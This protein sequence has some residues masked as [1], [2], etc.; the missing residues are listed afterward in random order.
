[1]FAFVVTAL[2]RGTEPNEMMK[3]DQPKNSELHEK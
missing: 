2:S 3:R 1:M